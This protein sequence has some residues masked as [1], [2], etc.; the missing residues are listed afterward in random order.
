MNNQGKPQNHMSITWNAKHQ[1]YNNYLEMY[2]TIFQSL[3]VDECQT[4]V[5]LWTAR[6]LNKLYKY[7]AGVRH[8]TSVNNES[9]QIRSQSVRSDYIN[10]HSLFPEIMLCYYRC[11]S[12]HESSNVDVVYVL[13]SFYAMAVCARLLFSNYSQN[14]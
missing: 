12:P 1:S 14:Q 7:R 13:F 5:S 2:V 3:C 9:A 6:H 8:L 11:T 10:T 4:R